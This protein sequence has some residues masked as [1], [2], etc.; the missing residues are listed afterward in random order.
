MLKQEPENIFAT[1]ITKA[2]CPYYTKSSNISLKRS[3]TLT[4]KPGEEHEQAN[5][6]HT[7]Q[8]AEHVEILL[9][10]LVKKYK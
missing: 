4:D 6:T 9:F 8:M 3:N 10:L 1:Y 5:S 2:V 7:L